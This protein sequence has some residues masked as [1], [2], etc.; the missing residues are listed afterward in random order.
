MQLPHR[1]TAGPTMHFY[2]H[3][4]CDP[5]FGFLLLWGF[6]SKEWACGLWGEGLGFGLSFEGLIGL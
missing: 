3:T 1:E 4:G 5:D 6:A 2:T